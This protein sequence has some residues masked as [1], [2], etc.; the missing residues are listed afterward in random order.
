MQLN[1]YSATETIRPDRRAGNRTHTAVKPDRI[2]LKAEVFQLYNAYDNVLYKPRMH[3]DRPTKQF[4]N[5]W[6]IKKDSAVI[7]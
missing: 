7:F 3:P 2:S 4:V 6:K 5:P 1:R